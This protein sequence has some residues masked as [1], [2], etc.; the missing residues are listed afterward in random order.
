MLPN[1]MGEINNILEDNGLEERVIALARNDIIN[2]VDANGEIGPANRYLRDFASRADGMALLYM[3]YELLADDHLPLTE[4]VFREE[5][6]LNNMSSQEAIRIY[7]L[8]QQLYPSKDMHVVD[9][10]VKYFDAQEG[11][12]PEDLA[13]RL[14]KRLE[15]DEYD[16]CIRGA[17]LKRRAH[18]LN[19][20][21]RGCPGRRFKRNNSERAR[22]RPEFVPT[23]REPEPEPSFN[24]R[25]STPVE[26]SDSFRDP[27]FEAAPVAVTV[28]APPQRP[29]LPSIPPPDYVAANNVTYQGEE[30]SQAN[31]ETYDAAAEENAR[32][33][34]PINVTYEG[35]AEDVDQ[36][37]ENDEDED[38][39]GDPLDEFR[40]EHGNLDILEIVRRE[41]GSREISLNGR[42]RLN[43]ISG[44]GLN[45]DT[46][47]EVGAVGHNYVVK[48]E[49]GAD[50]NTPQRPRNRRA[51]CPD[52]PV[53]RNSQVD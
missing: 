34:V 52:E 9:K 36:L 28:A 26:L 16:K 7:R 2:L 31:N 11:A 23:R 19:A 30:N 17:Q 8:V 20:D 4:M 35:P 32:A 10:L 48:D 12:I 5:T 33:A 25:G 18:S 43:V 39:V 50:G 49:G 15:I 41:E 45:E 51:A 53:S 3:I 1:E 14:K 22:R 47:I 29:A 46:R 21:E 42:Q 24:V 6:G 40:D 44:L 13:E 27:D 37:D 38:S